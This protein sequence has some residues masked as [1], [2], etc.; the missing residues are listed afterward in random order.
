MKEGRDNIKLILE[1]LH[2]AGC[3]SKIEALVNDMDSVEATLNFTTKELSVN[4]KGDSNKVITDIKK[5]VKDLEPDV[6]V[7]LRDENRG[8]LLV[9][10]KKSFIEVIKKPK[11]IKAI[12]GIG[13]FIGAQ[14]YSSVEVI[15]FPLFLIAYILIGQDVLLK[16]I[17]NIFKGRVFDENFLMTIATV[18]AFLIGEYP[19]AVAVMLFYKLGEAAQDM[20]VNRS[21]NSIA[22]LMDI[23]P[24]Y[25][26]LISGGVERKVEPQKVK[27]NDIILVKPGEKIPL[28][29]MII[30]GFASVDTT[31]L[32]GE[33]IPRDVSYGDKVLSGFINKDGLIKVRVQKEFKNS[34]VAKILDL[35]ENASSKKAKA[36]NFITKFARYYTPVVVLIALAIALIVPTVT[37]QSYETWIYRGLIFLVV[38]CPCA[39][40]ISIPLSYFGGIGGASKK[41]ILVK[42]SN[43]LDAL[44]DID[45]IVFD[46]TGTLTKGIFKVTDVVP[47]NGFDTDE[48]LRLCAYAESN[49]NHPISKSIVEYFGHVID[50]NIVENYAEISGKGIKCTVKGKEI[51]AGN[52]KL[53][54]DNN[55][56]IGEIDFVG[57]AVLVAISGKFA[58][59]ILINDEI[60]EDTID[61]IKSIKDMGIKETTM[62]TGDNKKVADKIAKD[63]GIDHVYAELLPQNKV[64]IF[65]KI[66]KGRRAAFVGDGIN[67]APVLAR[68][69]VG[70]AMGGLGSDAAIE[71]ADI[72]IMTDEISKVAE[73]IKISK[74]TSNI[75][76]QNIILALAVKGLVLALGTVGLAT[77]WEA[78]FADVGVTLLA[79]LN[80][81]RVLKGSKN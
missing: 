80:S 4:L 48:I 44:K 19:E 18:G 22:S 23:R 31:A 57:T 52:K 70:I 28:D 13:F 60:K 37:G 39:L 11:N 62:L 35:V 10:N 12:I 5:I 32:T 45:M 36:E 67:D 3:A 51:L 47:R 43:Y 38:S 26:N 69:D 41:G 75:V 66:S 24:D 55:V 56:H 46:K 54:E 7:S 34:T 65:E 78:V 40:V 30:E 42:G 61:G 49:S 33:S 20:A 21:R 16:A 17:K 73:A 8:A 15:A 27:V 79:V 25:A 77:M 14:L 29:G 53:L 63:I 74:L 59:Y 1:G 9:S 72:V 71:A 50:K 6:I 68:A 81:M 58:G 2:C 76:M 64:E